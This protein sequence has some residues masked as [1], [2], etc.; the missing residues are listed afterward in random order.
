MTE[1]P[2]IGW[3]GISKGSNSSRDDFGKSEG[4]FGEPQQASYQV[5]DKKGYE[6][7][8]ADLRPRVVAA[9]GVI[10]AELG[11]ISPSEI[12]RLAPGIKVSDTEVDSII[13][14]LKRLAKQFKSNDE[15]VVEEESELAES[16]AD[17]ADRVNSMRAKIDG[18]DDLLARLKLSHD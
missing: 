1:G 15:E 7:N 12:P 8:N 5:L 13:T 11:H 4:V 10:G 18:V 9:A 6:V 3:R 2:L 14:D 17:A 16:V